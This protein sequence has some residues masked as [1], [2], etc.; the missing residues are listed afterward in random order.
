[1]FPGR[2]KGAAALARARLRED[3]G[4]HAYQMLEAGVHQLAKGV[5]W[6]RGGEGLHENDFI[7]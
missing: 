3:A 5:I 2:R 7:M 1:M 6:N 4:F